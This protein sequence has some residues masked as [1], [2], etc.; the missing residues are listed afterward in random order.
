MSEFF[1]VSAGCFCSHIGGHMPFRGV[2]FW[3]FGDVSSPLGFKTSV[4]KIKSLLLLNFISNK[5]SN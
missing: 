2:L 1:D 5:C 4:F 3:T